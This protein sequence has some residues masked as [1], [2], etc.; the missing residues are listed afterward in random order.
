MGFLMP[1]I[2]KPPP[3]PKIP[4]P[5][6]APPIKP[7]DDSEADREI[8][9]QRRKKGISSTILTGPRGLTTEESVSPTSPNLL[10]GD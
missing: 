5:P 7:V 3:L 1:K 8:D 9:R 4:P 10:A 2:P 6:P